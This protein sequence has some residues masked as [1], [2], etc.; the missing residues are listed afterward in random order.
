MT[1]SSEIPFITVAAGFSNYHR[2]YPAYVEKF[3]KENVEWASY[4][5]RY[6][7]ED[8]LEEIKSHIPSD[9][10]YIITGHSMGGS[11]IIELLTREKLDDRCKGVILVGASRKLYPHPILNFIFRFPVPFIY[12]F[13]IFLILIYPIF[14]IAY[15]FNMHKA[16]QA[17]FESIIRLVENG[18]G[19]MKKEFN[20]CQRIV[21]LNVTDILPENKHIPALFI[22]L[23]K[24]MMVHEDDL[25]ETISFFDNAK[26]RIIE[27]DAIHLTH[28]FDYIVADIINEEMPF[29]GFK[30]V[31]NKEK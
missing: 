15:K 4:A 9:R 13:A 20:N 31:E 22:R 8:H 14:I 17:S 18:A 11:L 29:F 1:S 16:T 6:T 10:E 12:A 21:G 5:K 25:K 2:E 27:T 7:I 19:E 30:P 23:K 28:A 26:E 24:D 3:G